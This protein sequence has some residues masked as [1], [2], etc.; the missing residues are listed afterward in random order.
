[1]L[2]EQRLQ[3]PLFPCPELGNLVLK[4]LQL[5]QALFQPLLDRSASYHLQ[6]PPQQWTDGS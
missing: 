3:G 1:M 6:F 5:L 4:R 2:R